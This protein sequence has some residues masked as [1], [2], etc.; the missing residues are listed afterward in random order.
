MSPE[1]RRT[2]RLGNKHEK[3]PPERQ[4]NRC[5]RHQT[6]RELHG[7]GSLV[8]EFSPWVPRSRVQRCRKIF[9]NNILLA[10]RRRLTPQQYIGPQSAHRA[11]RERCVGLS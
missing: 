4:G 8:P 5:F 11:V 2:R 3:P 1:T 9:N 10:F 6:G 7:K